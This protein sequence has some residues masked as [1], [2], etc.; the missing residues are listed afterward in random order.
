MK[1]LALL[2]LSFLTT[3]VAAVPLEKRV[4]AYATVTEEVVVTVDLT[5]TVTVNGAAPAPTPSTTS[6]ADTA[7]TATADAGAGAG[8]VGQ[9]GSGDGAPTYNV[10]ASPTTTTA[11]EEGP[12]T[13][14]ATND[15]PVG[16][17]ATQQQMAAQETAAEH[18]VQP[19]PVYPAPSPSP[20]PT[21]TVTGQSSSGEQSSSGG[22]GPAPAPGTAPGSI[23]GPCDPNSSCE[24]EVTHYDSKGAPTSCG[25]MV[26]GDQE[27]IV[28]LSEELMGSM[29]NGGDDPSKLNPYCN[30]KVE[31][32]YGG[33][34][35]VATVKDKC[36]KPSVPKSA[37]NQQF[38]QDPAGCYFEQVDMSNAGWAE[39][40][41]DKK[42]G[43]LPIT[44]K[45]VS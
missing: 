35:V 27:V 34:S 28:A 24:G 23:I 22:G 9:Q 38:G 3:L 14:H 6:T 5:T 16:G 30:Q 41:I 33:K 2:G 40:G 15:V 7:T 1:Y 21:E 8:Q 17:P 45:F 4:Y 20:S 19:Q 37:E 42:K 32:S 36:P 13:T 26:N 29:S 25:M 43:R 12:A 31:V 18:V 44:W 39:L 10:P 11:V